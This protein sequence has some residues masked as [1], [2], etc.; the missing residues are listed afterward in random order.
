MTFLGERKAKTIGIGEYALNI[1]IIRLIRRHCAGTFIFSTAIPS[2][3]K[4]WQPFLTFSKGAYPIGGK[5]VVLWPWC[6]IG[7]VPK[8]AES[9]RKG[10]WQKESPVTHWNYRA[11]LVVRARLELATYCLEGSCSILMSYRTNIR[12]YNMVHFDDFSTKG[13]KL[14]SL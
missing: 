9:S 11:K 3:R 1:G 14:W 8:R 13:K 12:I 2:R 10:N 5:V 4:G 6:P 7:F